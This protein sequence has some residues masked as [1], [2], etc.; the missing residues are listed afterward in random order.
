[1]FGLLKKYIY[2]DLNGEIFELFI[3]VHIYTHHHVYLN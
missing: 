1:M 2:M 3:F